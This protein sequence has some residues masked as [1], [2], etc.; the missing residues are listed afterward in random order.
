MTDNNALFEYIKNA[1]NEIKNALIG[2]LLNASVGLSKTENQLLKNNNETGNTGDK[3]QIKHIKNN[4]LA[5]M[6]RGEMNEEYVKYYYQV[7]EKAEDFMSTSN[8]SQIKSS[9]E[10]YGMLITENGNNADIHRFIN[11]PNNYNKQELKSSNNPIEVSIKNKVYL[12]DQ[13]NTNPGPDSYETTLK[14]SYKHNIINKI[15]LYADILKSEI[16]SGNGRILKIFIPSHYP[17][18]KMIG[19]FQ[20]LNGLSFTT[21]F[22]KKY[23]YIVK[24][25]KG[26]NNVDNYNIVSFD[27]YLIQT[28]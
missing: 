25:Y 16:T 19:D 6:Q 2:V 17:I 22:G 14:C 13:Y 9:L 8:P 28:I 4:L 3:M 20:S 26:L 27:S 15:E 1:P 11:T 12:K 24:T 18:D 23:N 7:L 21:N 10:K 5:S